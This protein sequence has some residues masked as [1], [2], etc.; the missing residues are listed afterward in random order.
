MLSAWIAECSLPTI[1][2]IC[3]LGSLLIYRAAH[4]ASPVKHLRRRFPL[5]GGYGIV[6]S[7]VKPNG[8]AG[9]LRP[10]WPARP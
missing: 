3:V 1:G 10:R 4:E 8:S 9:A 2:K 7:F 5:V 6:M